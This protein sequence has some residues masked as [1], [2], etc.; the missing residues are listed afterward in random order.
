MCV[1][2]FMCL[3]GGKKGIEDCSNSF[4]PSIVLRLPPSPNSPLQHT[5]HIESLLFPLYTHKFLS[6]FVEQCYNG[7]GT[8]ELVDET[9]EYTNDGDILYV[10]GLAALCVNG[11]THTICD[12]NWNDDLASQFCAASGYGGEQYS[13]F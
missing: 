5:A 1:Y 4:Q 9:Y 13:K 11:A 6:E 12:A 2:L 8:I 10:E 7:D 3:R